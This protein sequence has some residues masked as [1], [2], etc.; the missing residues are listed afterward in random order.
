MSS[1]TDGRA[2]SFMRD[3][4]NRGKMQ[5][6]KIFSWSFKLSQFSYDIKSKPGVE[7]VVFDPFFEFAI[8]FQVP[9]YKICT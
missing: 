9:L 7:N 4:R 3:R 6:S 8:L 2:I 1:D 5:N